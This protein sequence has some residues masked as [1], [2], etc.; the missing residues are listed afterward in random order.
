MNRGASRVIATLAVA[1]VL[2]SCTSSAAEPATE[3]IENDLEAQLGLG[4]LSAS[5]VEPDDLEPGTTFTCTATTEDG[6]VIEFDG[7]V[8]DEETFGI[9]ATNAMPAAVVE[10]V[11]ADAAQQLGDQAGVALSADDVECPDGSIVIEGGSFECELTDPDD[12]SVFV[13]TVSTDGYDGDTW[14]DLRYDITEQ[15]R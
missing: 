10:E 7:I 9:W 11:E 12:G 2:V 14:V 6:E 15:I 1:V 3:L 8:E 5:C 4:E 13:M